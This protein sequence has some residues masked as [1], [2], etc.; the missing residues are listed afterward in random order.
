MLINKNVFQYHVGIVGSPSKPDVE[1]SDKNLS[2][3]KRLGFNTLQLNI[4]WGA[5]PADEPLNIEDV[6]ITG[7]EDSGR[8]ANIRKRQEKIR[9]RVQ[10]CKR[11]GFRSIF[12]FGAPYNG[13][14]G[15]AG[16]PLDNCFLDESVSEIYQKLLMLL[17]EQIPCI[18]D[19]L[20]YTYDQDA[21]I[22]SEFEQCDRCFGKPL[23]DRLPHFIRLMT[24][25]WHHINSSGVLWWEPWEL[26]A[27]QT[28]FI[29]DRLP[30]SGFGLCIHSN[31]GEV[32][33]TRPVDIWFRNMVSKAKILG[34]PVIAEIFMAQSCEEVEPLQYIPSPQLTY[35]QL[36]SIMG[37]AGVTGIKEYYGLIPCIHDP[38]LEMAG[39][40]F[41]NP[42]LT[43]EEYL[44]RI[45]SG[46]ANGKKIIK[47]LWEAITNGYELFPWDVSWFVREVGNADRDHGWHAA[48]IRG[49]QC[50]TP[51]WES[52]R[53]SIFMKTDDSQPHPWM[54][55][56][57][58][59]RCSLAAKKFSEAID[60]A[61]QLVDMLD[62]TLKD[63][64][65]MI[66]HDVDYLFRICRSYELHIRETNVAM[67]LRD[68]KNKNEELNEELLNELKK[69]VYEDYLNQEKQGRV[70]GIY[71][72]LISAP[73]QWLN[74]YLLEDSS[75]IL[76]KGYFSLTT[77]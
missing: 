68:Y 21:W 36:S 24:E 17:A 15:Y 55:E 73:E 10:Q 26:S 69:L 43:L 44:D 19:L 38:C 52:T 16:K 35:Y 53:H 7:Q 41:T 65:I 6:V 8:I 49:Q 3:L 50:S 70:T 34:I 59:L 23:H 12:H 54:L 48:F 45:A 60:C 56:D 13:E 11:Y 25:T 66:L 32:Q 76:E 5:R 20:L 57:I 18:D 1:W 29:M 61:K 39:M 27:G 42:E 47:R 51:S 37:M 72:S 40:I 30:V 22:C 9:L 28:L 63:E 74:K 71:Q 75:S 14:N 2:D 77:R 46:Y 31:I 4:A 67:M 33:K 64:V 58:Q 62:G